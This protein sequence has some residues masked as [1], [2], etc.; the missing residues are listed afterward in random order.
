[1]RSPVTIEREKFHS[2]LHDGKESVVNFTAFNTRVE[3]FQ[4]GG[5]DEEARRAKFIDIHFKRVLQSFQFFYFCAL[6]F[7]K[8]E[9]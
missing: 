3:Q 8:I 9:F 7:C 2:V 6:S 5:L 4:Y 1:M